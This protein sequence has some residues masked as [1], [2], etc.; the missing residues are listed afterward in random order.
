MQCVGPLW[1]PRGKEST[2]NA[3]DIG[4]VGSIPGSGIASGGEH[5]NPHHC[6][7]LGNPM[8]SGAW[9]ATVHGVAKNL[10]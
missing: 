9:W 7:Y 6:S 4:D 2:F 8:G 10:T 5:G 1:W 3:R